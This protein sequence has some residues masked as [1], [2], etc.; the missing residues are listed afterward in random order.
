MTDPATRVA[1]LL[2]AEPDVRFR[3][4]EHDRVIA[5]DL[6]GDVPHDPVVYLHGTPDSRLARHPDPRATY[7]AGIG[8]IAVDRPGFGHSG[9]DPDATPMR[10]GR[11]LVAL[12]DHLGVDRVGVAAWS[13]GAIWALG[14]AASAP[15]RVSSV[16]IVGGLVPFEAF[17]DPAV[18]A[19]AGDARLGMVESARDLGAGVAAEMIGPLLVPDP[20]T[21]QA[22]LEH[23][24]EHGAPELT[25][26][27]GADEQMAAATID[28][29]RFGTD[30]LIHDL[31]VQ[32]S[33]SGLDL[34]SIDVPVHLVTGAD[35]TVC[36]PAF[37]EWFAARLPRA[38]VTVVPG[39]GHG[40]LLA[41]WAGTLGKLHGDDDVAST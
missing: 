32:L 41:D 16:L 20:P 4:A 24:A 19:A 8:L 35:D 15:A 27:P 29:V 12:L 25:A 21:P 6:I 39:A 17:D 18:E 2:A 34:G 9:A 30:G 10:F 11:D 36:P 7:A 26:I 31:E 28:A 40:L 22:A 1:E 33:P 14:L 23:R 5:A 13:A 38:T 37:A 3:L